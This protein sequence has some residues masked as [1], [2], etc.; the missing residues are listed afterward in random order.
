MSFRHKLIKHEN[1]HYAAS[2]IPSAWKYP[3]VL[4]NLVYGRPLAKDYLLHQTLLRQYYRRAER[5]LMNIQGQRGITDSPFKPNQVFGKRLPEHIIDYYRKE[6]ILDGHHYAATIKRYY[7]SLDYLAV[8]A[9]DKWN[10]GL[11]AP[12]I[13][14]QLEDQIARW[15]RMMPGRSEHPRS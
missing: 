14:K 6:F 11:N 10:E 12:E 4:N 3:D 13:I 1:Y 7:Q 15:T 2:M 9:A 5:K 8:D